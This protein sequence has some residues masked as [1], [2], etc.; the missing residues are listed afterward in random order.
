MQALTNTVWYVNG[1]HEVLKSQACEILSIFGGFIG[2]NISEMSK[3]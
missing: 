1:H 3:H 2:Y